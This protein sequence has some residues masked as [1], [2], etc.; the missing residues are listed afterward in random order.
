M[1]SC[2]KTCKYF[3]NCKCFSCSHFKYCKCSSVC[4]DGYSSINPDKIQNCKDY[5]YSKEIERYMQG[6]SV[7][8]LNKEL[9]N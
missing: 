1:S 5:E 6:T 3:N 8:V 2:N 7:L 9:N 4:N